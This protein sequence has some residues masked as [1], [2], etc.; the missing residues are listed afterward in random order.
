[1]EFIEKTQDHN[2]AVSDIIKGWGSDII[3]TRGTIYRAHDLDGIL[4]YDDGKIA[5]IG[6]YR[7]KKDCEIVLL[8]T[9]IH[10][11]GI[12]TQIIE[13]IKK[14]AKSSKCKRVWLIT[15]NANIHALGFYQKRGFHI[16]NIYKNAMENSRRIKPEIP[17][18]E[19]GI[20]IRDEIEFEIKL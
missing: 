12:G 10:N 4:A 16:S 17:E 3:V 19:D 1:M 6:L 9:F 7:I 20:E 5:G 18:M 2:K 8:E 11:R 15:T 13:R 14:I